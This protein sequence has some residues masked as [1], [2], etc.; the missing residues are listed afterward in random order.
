M[1]AAGARRSQTT[2]RSQNGLIR[3]RR[4]FDCDHSPP[5]RKMALRAPLYSVVR[6]AASAHGTHCRRFVLTAAG[7]GLAAAAATCLLS[8]PFSTHLP[9]AAAPTYLAPSRRGGAGAAVDGGEHE[10][11]E[12]TWWR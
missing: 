7:F 11:D 5:P 10:D 12:D 6:R 4:K 1:A 2:M 8:P 9:R 3:R